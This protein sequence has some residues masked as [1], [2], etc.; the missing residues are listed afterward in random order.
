MKLNPAIIFA[1]A[2][3]V[4]G[5]GAGLGARMFLSPAPKPAETS[6]EPD[7]APA[8]DDAHAEKPKKKS[9]KSGGH[10]EEKKEDK[11]YFKFSR[12]FV[13]PVL[14]DGAPGATMVLD[15]LVEMKPGFEDL[16]SDEPALRDAVLR[17][18]LRKTSEGALARIFAEPET[19]DVLRAEILAEVDRATHG[20]AQSILVLDVGYQKY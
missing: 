16:Y 19:M 18:L 20:A 11:H 13:V 12:Q 5:V 8:K 4:L 3:V 2:G 10:G 7:H 17:A 6:A 9:G 14:I 15:V 1:L